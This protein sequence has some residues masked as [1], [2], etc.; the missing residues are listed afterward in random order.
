MPARPVDL[1]DAVRTKA[2][3]QGAEGARWLRDLDAL[4]DDVSAEWG[5]RI[6]E[7]LTGGSGGLV[8]AAWTAAGAPV[9]LKLAIPDG[10]DGHGPFEDEVAT[11]LLGAGGGYVQVLRHDVDRRAI[12]LERLGRSLATLGLPVPSQLEVIA[13][14]LALGWRP[15]GEAPLPSGADKARWLAQFID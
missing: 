4:V 8:A 12:L 1:P 14:T 3:A 11:L 2:R 10:L 6:G 15:V 5:V 7:V 9:V 13:R